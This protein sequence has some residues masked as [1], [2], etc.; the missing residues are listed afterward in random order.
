MITYI[1]AVP[2]SDEYGLEIPDPLEEKSNEFLG[3]YEK[4]Y[5]AN[6]RLRCIQKLKLPICIRAT[7]KRNLSFISDIWNKNNTF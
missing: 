7:R 6:R 2:I 5:I 4:Q 1:E 3:L